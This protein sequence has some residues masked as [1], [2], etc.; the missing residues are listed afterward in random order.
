MTD[1]LTQYPPSV[2]S[3]DHSGYVG[4]TP[5]S[6]SQKYGIFNQMRSANVSIKEYFGLRIST[7]AGVGNGIFGGYDTSIV[8]NPAKIKYQP[9]TST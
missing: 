2:T 1:D 8:P 9:S 4:I 3:M 7:K 5:S 6:S